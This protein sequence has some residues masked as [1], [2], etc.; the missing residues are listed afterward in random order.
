M[1]GEQFTI[2][3]EDNAVPFCIKAPRAMTY[4]YRDKLKQKLDKL[5]E[6]EIIAPVTELR[7]C[8]SPI[9]VVP[10]LTRTV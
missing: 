10:K 9:I 2:V 8:C 4:V 6:H 7:E 1:P 3:L 5:L